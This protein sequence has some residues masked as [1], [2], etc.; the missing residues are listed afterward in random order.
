MFHEGRRG[1]NNMYC[2]G[3][4]GSGSMSHH[5][6][7]AMSSSMLSCPCVG[8][9]C[10]LSGAYP[11]A[12]RLR[13]VLGAMSLPLEPD[14][15]ATCS[16]SFVAYAFTCAFNTIKRANTCVQSTEEARGDGMHMY[17]YIGERL[18][19]FRAC[20]CVCLCACVRVSLCACLCA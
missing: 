15:I 3:G 8:A 2:S 18:Q 11:R 13:P 16:N 17:I 6:G 12:R 14:E 20:V 19:Q 1:V 5:P 7:S 4:T 9:C 10:L